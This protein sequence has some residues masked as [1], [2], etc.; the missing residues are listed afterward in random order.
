MKLNKK[1]RLLLLL[2]AFF[3]TNIFKRVFSGQFNENFILFLSLGDL[4][5]LVLEYFE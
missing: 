4:F 1:N 2:I 3:H 5:F